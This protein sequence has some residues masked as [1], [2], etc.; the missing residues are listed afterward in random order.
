MLLTKMLC[1]WDPDEFVSLNAPT[2]V[3]LIFLLS[4]CVNKWDVSVTNIIA[5]DNMSSFFS[6]CSRRYFKIKVYACE[7]LSSTK[8]SDVSSWSRVMCCLHGSCDSC[9]VFLVFRL[10]VLACLAAASFPLSN[11]ECLW[12][13]ETRLSFKNVWL[14]LVCVG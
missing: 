11:Q 14:C 6:V 10:P 3:S 12:I 9:G 13:C 5:Y 1:V 8:K 7:R 2:Q 4:R